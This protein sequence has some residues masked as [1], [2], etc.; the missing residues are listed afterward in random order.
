VE[1]FGLGRT[2]EG[3]GGEGGGRTRCRS[4]VLNQDQKQKK[5]VTK[6]RPAKLACGFFFFAM[7]QLQRKGNKSN[8]ELTKVACEWKIL[9]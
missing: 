3:R 6:A 5:H 4:L 2:G 7:K 9:V 1:G 8:N